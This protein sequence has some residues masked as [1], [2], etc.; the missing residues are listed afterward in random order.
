MGFLVER[1]LQRERLGNLR[2]LSISKNLIDFSSN[3][4]LGLAR[5]G[6][7]ALEVDREC[8][9]HRA[10]GCGATG[11]RLLTGNTAYAEELERMIALFHGYESGLLFGCGYMANIGLLSAVAN[12]GDVIFYD[13]WVHASTHDGIRLS[14]ADAFPFRHND[15]EHLESR[16]RSSSVVGNRFI[17]VESIYSTDGSVAPLVEICQLAK[18]YRALVIVDEAHAVGVCGPAGRGLVFENG[19]T[20]EVFAQIVTFGKALGTYG[21]IILGSETCRRTLINFARSC[22]YTTALPFHCLAAIK[23]SYDLFPYMDSERTHLRELV[24]CFCAVRKS[25]SQTHIQAIQI[26]GNKAVREA[27]KILECCGYDLRPLLSPTVQRGSE[28]LRFCLH[29][30]NRESE[31]MEFLSCIESL[32]PALD[33]T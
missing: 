15:I 14:R 10:Y 31:L 18:K 26:K 21:A 8:M 2:Q 12:S 20:S 3:D 23:C 28:I 27:A 4:Y 13:A 32:L 22:I 19:L 29:A 1:L 17:C 16:L 24:G 11:S 25:A 6:E 33:L 9:R 5:S 7:L 30:F